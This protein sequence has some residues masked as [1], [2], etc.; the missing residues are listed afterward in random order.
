MRGR[1]HVVLHVHVVLLQ[2]VH[3]VDMTPEDQR[4]EKAKS[5]KPGIERQRAIKVK[6]ILSLLQIV[7]SCGNILILVK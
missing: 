3:V 4:W 1:V 2:H 6:I 7:L 5:R